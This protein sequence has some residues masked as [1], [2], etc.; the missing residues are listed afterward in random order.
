MVLLLATE[1]TILNLIFFEH[2]TPLSTLL[3]PV[4]V[5]DAALLQVL[6]VQVADV[7][8]ADQLPAFGRH[9]IAVD[10]ATGGGVPVSGV[11]DGP[12]A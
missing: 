4:G 5:G 7:V 1:N 11:V 6:E 8:P 9:D 12:F 3:L 10:E 2:K